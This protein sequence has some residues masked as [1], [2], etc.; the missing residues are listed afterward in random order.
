ME[1]PRKESFSAMIALGTR[2]ST[3]RRRVLSRY[4]NL[5]EVQCSYTKPCQ[6][7]DTC[8]SSDHENNQSLAHGQLLQIHSMS[9]VS[10][11]CTLISS[12]RSLGQQVEYY[13]NKYKKKCIVC[14]LGKVALREH[15]GRTCPTTYGLCFNC[16]E[17]GHG[18]SNCKHGRRTIGGTCPRCYL[19]EKIGDVLFHPNGWDNCQNGEALKFFGLA[20]MKF[21]RIPIDWSQW[22]YSRDN[23]G[24]LVLWQQFVEFGA[25]NS[26]LTLFRN[27]NWNEQCYCC[28]MNFVN[29][30]YWGW[31]K[32]PPI[33]VW[34][35]TNE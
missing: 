32:T 5:T 14:H 18:A 2:D 28:V 35:V 16:F 6:Q 4:F 29:G 9:D 15:A 17:A 26:W 31:A 21:G 12:E 23:H 13:T 7:C 33:W 19:P 1:G 8:S 11:G 10:H 27:K 20:A 25:E 22:L 24:M 30:M 34:P 3:C